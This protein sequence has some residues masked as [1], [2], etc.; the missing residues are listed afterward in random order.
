[1]TAPVPGPVEGVGS[2]ALDAAVLRIHD[3]LSRPVGAGFLV[4][5]DLAVTCAHVVSAALAGQGVEPGV[6]S[7]VFVDLPLLPVPSGAGRPAVAGV[8]AVVEHWVPRTPERGG[9]VAVLRL[10]A[11]LA[12]ARPV[13]PVET[14]AEN[15][16]DHPVRVF[17]FPVG[18]SDGVWHAGVLRGR[19]GGGLLQVDLASRGYRV[20]GGFSG[21]PVWDDR[22]GGVVG[23]VTIAEATDPPVS[24]LTPTDGLTAAWPGLRAVAMPPSPFRSLTSFQ[25]S[26]AA[27]FH[28][29]YTESEEVAVLTARERWVTVVGPSGSGK[30]SLA[31]AGVVPRRRAAGALAVTLR[32]D[33]GSSPLSALAAALLPLLEPSLSATQRLERAPVLAAVLAG[34][35][36][37]ADLVP[38]LLELHG[39]NQLLLVLDQ[40]EELLVRGRSAVDELAAVLFTDTLPNTVRVLT[41]LRADFLE[42]ALAHP[43]LGPVI[44]RQVYALGP[45]SRE[46]LHQVVTAPVDAVAGVRYAPNLAER[47]LDDTG[48]EPGALPLL[49]FTLDLLWRRQD[50]GLLTHQAYE[51]LGGVKGALGAYANDVLRYKVSPEEERGAARRLFTQLVRVPLGSLSATRRTALRTELGE[52]EW[53]IAQR[54]ADERLLVVGRSAE[55][56]DTVELAHE[57]LINAWDKLRAW[58]EEDRAF[59]AWREVLRHDRE[60]WER[61]GRD[62]D[63]LPKRITL[64]GAE[65]WLHSRAGDL[66]EAERDYLQRGRVHR[67]SRRRRQGTVAAAL[68]VTLLAAVTGGVL[69]V[70]ERHA[71][72]RERDATAQKAAVVNSKDLAARAQAL[73]GTDPGL[74]AQFA[75]AA[76]RTSPTQEAAAQL[77]D[78]SGSLLNS[79]VGEAGKDT[80][81]MATSARAS[82]V[83]AVNQDGV[84]R[85]WDIAD[86]DAP[87]LRSTVEVGLTGIA[88]TPDGSHLAASCGTGGG[89]CLW[90]LADPGKPVI[91]ARLPLATDPAGERAGVM[92]MATSADGTLLAAALGNGD[93]RL[94]SIARPTAPT[95]LARLRNPTGQGPGALAAVAFSPRGSLLATTVLGGRTQLWDIADPVNPVDPVD[96]ANPATLETGYK[97]IVFSPDGGMLAAGSQR[98]VGLWRLGDPAHPEAVRVSTGGSANVSAVAFSRD[99]RQLAYGGTDVKDPKGDLCVV[100]LSADNLALGSAKSSCMKTAAGLYAMAT[101]GAGGL[102]TVGGDG[103]LRR[104]RAP[105]RQIDEARL[106]GGLPSWSFSPDGRLM[107]AAQQVTA[108]APTP[109]TQSVGLWDLSASTG[110]ALVATLPVSV[111]STAFLRADALLTVGWEGE[112]RLWNVS[113][114]HHP[115]KAASLGT[116]DFPATPSAVG[117]VIISFGVTWDDGGHRIAVIR[118][119]VLHLWRVTDSLD[120]TEAG[121]IPAPDADGHDAGLLNH[122]RTAYLA[123]K[124]GFDWWDVS[125]PAKPRRTGSSAIKPPEGSSDSGGSADSLNMGSALS[126]LTPAGTVMAVTSTPD[127]TCK[128]SALELFHF[129][130]G[131]EPT[132]RV[133]VPGAFNDVL[134]LSGDGRLLAA[135]ANNGSAVSLWDTGDPGHP[136]PETTIQTVQGVKGV[137]FAQNGALMA[138]WNSSTLELW[139]VRNPTAPVLVAS[140]ANPSGDTIRAVALVATG[141]TLL[142]ASNRTVS[143]LDTDPARLA[144]RLCSY[145]RGSVSPA[146]WRLYAPDI[147]YRNPCPSR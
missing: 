27:V 75:I 80:L 42:A 13:R 47:L 121:S 62:H 136:R 93:T 106:P 142:V 132:S 36:G 126:R 135:G 107:A 65:P 31:M 50:A 88:L 127:I 6:G 9:D 123:S 99:G 8:M 145:S 83:A 20:S 44:G 108:T 104:W 81:V 85:I 118:G 133:T 92:S 130:A 56:V 131:G 117:D 77:Y 43:L 33:S 17:G 101:T 34:P 119:R 23:M 52:D 63:L 91:A 12:G 79:V 76:H 22:L 41:T 98:D 143:L 53:R 55:G 112:V 19:Q 110:P 32:P 146:Q 102:L 114:P 30:S 109:T 2:N 72:A 18:R 125:D 78:L 58:V 115:V 94:W 61:G 82:L 141:P 100:P 24:Y 37:M 11:P 111:R 122:G 134:G 90:S 5:P 113:D 67:R 26:D 129:T 147:A 3:A 59:L 71:T 66:S 21:S 15:V 39:A 103:V 51:A 74:A 95:E 7:W 28:G 69:T 29:R 14:R 60:R 68:C 4:A 89:L 57:A 120:A 96:P 137:E 16:W 139:D 140:V 54:L 48:A 73:G 46:Q 25:E 105:V 84:V 97:S 116:A 70:R 45:M 86:P 40:F 35:Q 124:A 49:G 144:D 1:M 64:A 128:C 38:R 138:I 87:A 10:A